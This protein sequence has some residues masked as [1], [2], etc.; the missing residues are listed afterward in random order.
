MALTIGIDVSLAVGEMAG[1]GRYAIELTQALAEIDAVNRYLLFP[2]FLYIRHPEFRRFQGPS[3]SNFKVWGEELSDSDA[4]S[5]WARAEEAER[6]METC[7][8]IHTTTFSVPRRHHAVVSTIHDLSF[9]T[10]PEC[11]LEAN[12]THCL[13]GTV[14][15]VLRARR[16]IA[17]SQHTARDLSLYLNAHPPLVATIPHG[18]SARFLQPASSADKERVCER[19]GLQPPFVLTIGSLEPRK[20]LP[21][22]VEAWAALP[23]S[24][25]R[26][27]RLVIAGGR[28]WLNS[29]IYRRIKELETADSVA[30]PGYV[31]DEDLPALYQSAIVFAYPSLYEGFGLP[32]LEAMASGVP[33]LTSASSSLEELGRGAAEMVNPLDAHEIENGLRRLLLDGQLRQDYANLGRA[34]ASGMTWRRVAERT[35]GV[36]CEAA[37]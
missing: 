2:L 7:D 4:F 14:E 26:E 11:H 30:L 35:L 5:T 1:T 15:S 19:Y 10:H 28:G 8:V 9:V 20:N 17:V 25:R 12:R 31:A 27:Y 13:K 34:R 16:L 24:L 3:S 22:L 32:V 36:Y 21:A 18:V 33:V 6:V 29:N 37:G 23:A